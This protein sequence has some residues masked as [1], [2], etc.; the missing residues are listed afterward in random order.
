MQSAPLKPIIHFVC[1]NIWSTWL[2]RGNM[3]GWNEQ[4]VSP[5]VNMQMSAAPPEYINSCATFVHLSSCSFHCSKLTTIGKS[6]PADLVL[7]VGS[8]TTID[9]VRGEN[10]FTPGRWWI[11]GRGA[12]P[13]L[14]FSRWTRKWSDRNH[15][16]AF[17]P[18]NCRISCRP[19]AYVD[20]MS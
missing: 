13:A 20:C 1:S 18:F 2:S 4:I 9:E 17:N 12:S 8:E 11:A 15:F 14:N 19:F 5:L 7:S 10:I 16:D 6:R 3:G